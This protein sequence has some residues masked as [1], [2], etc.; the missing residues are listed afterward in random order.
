MALYNDPIYKGT[1]EALAALLTSPPEG[2]GG[3]GGPPSTGDV[4][5]SG[6]IGS[7]VSNLGT[8]GAKVAQGALVGS[9]ANPASYLGMAIPMSSLLA[10]WAGVPQESNPLYGVPTA[11]DVQDA[12][13]Y[14]GYY[15][16]K[17]AQAA[18]DAALGNLD[19]P[20]GPNPSFSYGQD[21]GASAG[22]PGGWGGES[23][24]PG[25]GAAGEAKGAEGPGYARGGVSR[26]MRG[27]RRAT[28]GEAGPEQAIFIPQAMR[29]PG[30]QGREV[31]VRRA[32]QDAI[33]ALYA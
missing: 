24:A 28:F 3:W 20:F 7:N 30:I 21:F 16:G 5:M 11:Q 15:A 6:P 33:R 17:E 19:N 26:A 22:S 25:V 32:L 4:S 12:Y 2:G 8:I 27:P 13:D 23:T 14:G 1:Y 31:Q 18:R 9:L 10:R 29:R